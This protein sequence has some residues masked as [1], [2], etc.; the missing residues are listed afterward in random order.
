MGASAVEKLV[1]ALLE[2]LGHGALGEIEAH[3]GGIQLLLGGNG[4]G[5]EEIL[6][7]SEVLLRLR[8]VSFDRA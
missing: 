6:S 2:G 5:G 3:H 8:G 4:V 7:G 1:V